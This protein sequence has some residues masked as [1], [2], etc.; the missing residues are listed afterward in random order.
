MKNSLSGT[1]KANSVPERG[2]FFWL[3]LTKLLLKPG[4]TAV[5]TLQELHALPKAH[6]GQVLCT[7]VKIYRQNRKP[8]GKRY[9]N[10]SLL[11][12]LK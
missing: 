8:G 1:E 10:E 4:V 3:P 7:I 12:K 2:L 9:T 11:V 5:N 6:V